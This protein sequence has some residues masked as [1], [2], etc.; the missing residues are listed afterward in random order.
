MNYLR[1]LVIIDGAHLKDD[2]YHGVNLLVVGMDGNNQALPIAFGICQGEASAGWTWFFE[3][4]KAC[5]SQKLNLSIISDRPPAILK[6]V[7]KIFPNAFHGFCCRHLMMNAAIKKDKHKAVYWEACKA[8]TIE[9]FDE[10]MDYIQSAIPM[11]YVKLV[12]AGF[13]RWSRAHCLANHYNYLT[14]NSV[15]SANLL[16]RRAHK[17]PV[18]HLMEFF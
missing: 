7:K 2:F 4:L 10:C 16:S 14:S 1:P 12:K 13:T 5:I 17:L 9:A 6:S 8:Y 15:E 18:I 11:T 3:E